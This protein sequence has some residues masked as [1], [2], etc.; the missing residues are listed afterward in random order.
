LAVVATPACF[1][2]RMN[3][4]PW[5]P[6]V[7]GLSPNSRCSAPIGAFWLAVAA[8]TTSITGA[9]SRLTPA[10]RSSRPHAAACRCSS[11]ADSCPWASAGGITVKP[12]PLE[13]LDLAALLVGRDEEP[14]PG[15]GGGR[16]QRLDG[17]AGLPVRGH[18]RGAGAL[19][20][21]GAEVVGLDRLG[22]IGGGGAGD[23]DQEQLTDSLG[24]AHPGEDLIRAGGWR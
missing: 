4:A 16:R 19:P 11:A 3:A 1:M 18:A 14:D 22:H 7:W 23:T 21:Q 15:G 6:V 8:G 24:L 5:V 10:D 20:Q 13:F 2:P 12:G 17:L 9:R